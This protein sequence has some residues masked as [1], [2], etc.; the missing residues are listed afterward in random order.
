MVNYVFKFHSKFNSDNGLAPAKPYFNSKD[1]F[2]S[3]YY[4][5]NKACNWVDTEEP[6]NGICPFCGDSNIK[7]Q[8]LLKPWGFAPVNGKAINDAEADAEVSYAEL[9]CYSSPIID[10]DMEIYGQYKSLRF[11]KLV[12]Q[13]LLIMNQGPKGEGF[14]ICKDCGAAV[15]GDDIGEL[16]KISQPFT[17]P[18]N[19]NKICTHTGEKINTFLGHQFLTDMVLFEIKVDDSIINCELDGFWIDSA[20]I[21][22]SEAVALAASQLLD[23]DFNDI[24]SGYRI[25]K[26]TGNTYID[27]YLFDSL[28]SGAGYSSMLTDKISELFDL[29]R[30]LL[31]C[32]NH[33]KTAC[34]DCLEHYWNQRIQ[35]KLDRHLAL[36]LLDWMMFNTLPSDLTNEEKN[37]WLY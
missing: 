36:Q 1:Y 32:K 4:C 13:K 34:H 27:I 3:I 19:R 7:Q 21:S 24:K 22:L 29:T 28:A 6:K 8:Y 16:K 15:P 14:T 30:E 25:R 20:A 17:Y 18:Y 26:S 23:V 9:P 31:H 5:D 10:S 33:C 35:N 37:N 11:G 12:D 2:K